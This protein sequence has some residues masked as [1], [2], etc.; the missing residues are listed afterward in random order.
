[1]K[2]I[3]LFALLFAEI[4]C[5]SC[6]KNF[7]TDEE[8]MNEDS[9]YNLKVKSTETILKNGTLELLAKDVGGGTNYFFKNS[10]SVEYFLF[11]TCDLD[12]S[13]Y[14]EKIEWDKINN[15]FSVLIREKYKT[16]FKTKNRLI[17]YKIVCDVPMELLDTV[18][19]VYTTFRF[20]SNKFIYVLE[21]GTEKSIVLN[22]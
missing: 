2:N 14:I 18:S 9:P 3:I 17:L 20:E 16:N 1:M 19:E 22:E 15:C 4:V 8:L 10:S 13:Q 7:V 5:V 11:I 12:C 21:N 6:E